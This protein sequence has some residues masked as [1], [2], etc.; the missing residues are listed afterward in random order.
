MNVEQMFVGGRYFA[1]RAPRDDIHPTIHRLLV[2]AI[3]CNSDRRIKEEDMNFDVAP[4]DWPWEGD[5]G[6]TESALLSWLSRYHRKP[7]IMELRRVNPERILQAY[8]FSSQ[9]KYSAV[10]MR[11]E[12]KDETAR[13]YYKGAAERIIASCTRMIDRDGNEV[14]TK[15]MALSKCTV[16]K[17][18]RD[19]FYA[20]EGQ[21]NPDELTLC[22]VHKPKSF[23]KS[24]RCQWTKNGEECDR[25]AIMGTAEKG[26]QWCNDPAHHP[27]DA[28]VFLLDQHPMKMV[29]NF[30]RRGLRCIAFAYV[31]K[32]PIVFKDSQFETPPPIAEGWTL[33]GLVGIKDPLRPNSRSAVMTMQQAGIIVRMVTGDNVDTANFIARD[34]GIVTN[35][36]HLV[37]EGAAFTRELEKNNEYKAIHGGKNS[38]EFLKLVKN[39]RVMARCKPDDK[40]QL[41]KFLRRQRNVV[42]VTGP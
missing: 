41:V 21:E 4:E 37:M 36:D 3:V 29:T 16:D 25:W 31:D 30:A 1:C 13:Q 33:I 39:L 24:R 15:R 7:H 10:V 2:D 28:P 42:G 14:E 22:D 5:G 19:A 23:T 38:P 6:A 11:L 9:N 40:T 17:C 27:S 32:V 26:P 18:E 35:P 8:P 12:E 20:V 34:C